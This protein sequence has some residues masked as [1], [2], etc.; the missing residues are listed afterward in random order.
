MPDVLASFS[1]ARP[2]WLWA[3]ILPLPVALWLRLTINAAGDARVR[4]YADPGLLPHLIKTRDL[5]AHRKWWR[6]ALWS[7]LWILG[8]LAMAGPRWGY[9]DVQHYQPDNAVVILMDIS[10]S[11]EANDVTP[12]R[13][14]RARQEV[15]DLL[16][17]AYGVRMG[18]VAFASVAHVITP[19]TEDVVS[20]SEA[21][22]ALSSDLVQLPGSRLERALERSEQLLD[23]Q[24]VEGRRSVLL[25]SD[26]DFVEPNLEARIQSLARK[27]IHFSVLAV[28]TEEGAVVP[29]PSGQPLRGRDGRPIRSRLNGLLLAELADLGGGVM[30]EASYRQNDTRDL[31]KALVDPGTPKSAGSGKLRVWNE[32]FYWLIVPLLLLLLPQFRRVTSVSGAGRA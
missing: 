1:L 28:G 29:D 32:T 11:M 15:E 9:R 20:I 23:G 2:D 25:V 8:V 19:I 13:I 4:R 26:G 6:F 30:V 18:L 3:L 31:L 7:L 12:S 5:G 17:Q 27:G 16:R 21:L 24:A 14:A 10:R 22:P